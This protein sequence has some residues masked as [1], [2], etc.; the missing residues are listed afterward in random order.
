MPYIYNEPDDA[1]PK[2]SCPFPWA[3]TCPHLVQARLYPKSH[4]N[5]FFNF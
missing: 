4:L 3:D 2:Q 1:P 5:F